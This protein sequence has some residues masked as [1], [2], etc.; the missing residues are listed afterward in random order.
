MRRYPIRSATHVLEEL[1]ERHLRQCLPK[2]WIVGRPSADYGVDLRVEIFDGEKAKGLEFLIQL[3]AAKQ[4][5][6]GD[7]ETIELKTST[8]NHLWDKLQVVMLVKYVEA[9]DEAYWLFLREIPEPDQNQ[10]TFTVRIP[11][12][13]TLS[14]IKWAAVRDLVHEITTDKLTM[15][16]HSR[17]A[18]ESQA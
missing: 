12:T 18:S 11:K 4:G 16:R 5:D 14:G 13:R 3:K 6:S 15:R 17:A 1:S 2:N 9:E 10:K 8:Y 7:H